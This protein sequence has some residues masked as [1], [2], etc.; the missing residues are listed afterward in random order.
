MLKRQILLIFSLFFISF[1]SVSDIVP[2]NV[3]SLEQPVIQLINV[4]KADI[5]TLSKLKGIQARA[6]FVLD[7]K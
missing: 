2:D 1:Y 3:K 4:N 6:P 7:I 5:K